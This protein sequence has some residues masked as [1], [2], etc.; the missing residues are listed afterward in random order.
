MLDLRKDPLQLKQEMQEAV[1]IEL[2]S[3]EEE[4]YA[5]PV[6]T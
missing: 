3:S 2:I 6:V 4:R 5:A 1:E